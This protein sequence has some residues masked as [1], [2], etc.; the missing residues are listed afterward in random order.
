MVGPI[1]ISLSPYLAFGLNAFLI[2]VD[3]LFWGAS[4]LGRDYTEPG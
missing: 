1:Y 4:K 3:A 2:C